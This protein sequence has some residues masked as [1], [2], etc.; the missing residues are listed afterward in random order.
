MASSLSISLAKVRAEAIR[1]AM[2]TISADDDYHVGEE[3]GPDACLG[4]RWRAALGD[5]AD[6]VERVAD[7]A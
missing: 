6:M 1:L 3:F 2:T 5:Y 7:D 4:C